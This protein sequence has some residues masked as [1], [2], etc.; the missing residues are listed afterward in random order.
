M[1]ESLT[2]FA[3]L[4]VVILTVALVGPYFVDWTAQRSWIEA[5]LSDATGARVRV[6]GAIDVKLLPTPSLHLEK[7]VLQGPNSNDV[8]FRAADVDLQMAV[9]P[10]LR[11]QVQFIE[12]D[13]EAPEVQVTMAGDG[14]VVLPRVPAKLPAEMQFSAISLRHGRLTIND[15]SHHHIFSVAGLDLDAKAG[16]L[17]GPFE[18][19]G[20]FVPGGGGRVGFHFSTT[21]LHGSHLDLK[22]AIDATANAPAAN[23]D[24]ALEFAS[25]A[26]GSTDV[27]FVG[28]ARFSGRLAL[29]GSAILPWKIRGSLTADARRATFASLRLQLGK[30]GQALIANGSGAIDFSGT[31]RAHAKLR[32][33]QIDIDKLLG[34]KSGDGADLGLFVKA[35]AGALANPKLADRIPIPVDLTFDSPAVM[36]GGG[37]LSDVATVLKLRAGA[38]IGLDFQA[39]GPGRSHLGLSG[40]LDTGVAAAFKGH[41]RVAVGD[42]S[43]LVHWLAPAMPQI[44]DRLRPLPF[45]MIDLTGDME[46]SAAGFVGRNLHIRADRSKLVGTVSFTRAMGRERARVFADLDADALDL[47]A[48]PDLS[49]PAVAAA[50][51][52]LA[53]TLDARAVRVARFGQG[54]IDAGHIHFKLTKEGAK[55]ELKDLSIADL[56]GASV[57]A[58][59]AWT[60]QALRFDAKLDAKRLNDLAALIR[61]VAPGAAANALARRATAL[62]PAHVALTVEGRS[63]NGKLHL[64]GLALR[65]TARGTKI[66]AA[67]R[68]G[69]AESRAVTANLR[70]DATNTPMLLRQIGLE[71]LPLTGFGRAHLG[72]KLS[73]QPSQGFAAEL[74]GML[75]G[76]AV[77]FRGHVG[78][79]PI[80]PRA[81]GSFTVKASNLTPLLEIATVGVP[82]ATT[83]LATKLK[84][85]LTLDRDRLAFTALDG[86]FGESRIKGDL[87]IDLAPVPAKARITGRLAFDR[88]PLAALTT[89]ALGPPQPTKQGALW[90]SGTFVSSLAQ[91][92]TA[93]IAV[94]AAAL[95]LARGAVARQ[96]RLHLALAPSILTLSDV[97]MKIGDGRLAG[98]LTVR[99][100]RSKVLAAGAVDFDGVAFHTRYASGQ[101]SGSL[102]FAATGRSEAALVAS[103]AGSGTVRLSGLTLQ[104][105]DPGALARIVTET[106]RGTV[107]VDAP[108]IRSALKRQLDR[109]ALRVGD[110]T[111]DANMAA[112]VLRLTPKGK[113]AG[114]R[115][116]GASARF[117]AALDLRH[118]RIAARAVLTS[119]SAPRDWKGPPPRAAVVWKGPVGAAKRKLDAGGFFDALASRAL[120]RAAA[121]AEMLEQDIQ[122]R[123]YF[124]RY[125]KGLQFL[126]RREKEI[127][128][129]EAQEARQAEAAQQAAE[130]ARQAR[131]VRA[132]VQQRASAPVVPRLDQNSKSP[133][134]P[135]ALPPPAPP[136]PL[137]L[138]LL[139]DPPASV[140]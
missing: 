31:P 44:S 71:S 14:S 99:R 128:A 27:S 15:P 78:G 120:A 58:T 98:H 125:L 65:G 122:E 36:L 39:D 28:K 66:E 3:G 80:A 4:L 74:H 48:L 109:A 21:V 8:S 81:Q 131:A 138:H 104:K 40:S 115:A 136:R 67:A 57:S 49:G 54:M 96:A 105:S 132:E 140:Q 123:A 121:R 89:L 103:L 26:A 12:A 87:S 137:D 88:L 106:D 11:G 82:D 7:V 107:A 41:V 112:G 62:S 29:I 102:G 33:R 129:Y 93:K 17:V 18:G 30:E 37:T 42:T 34:A 72:L 56:G 55:T 25:G 52:D 53:L 6:A 135:I 127:A 84:G 61:R 19:S 68:P 77:T 2:I 47:D 119:K 64:T 10:L 70:L 63:V 60:P 35:L 69:S 59:G 50:D 20:Q 139:L 86:S 85:R 76:T 124:N 95:D 90:S 38:P 73:G 1:R 117:S 116:A 113:T 9:T 32:S 75:A 92:P 108:E 51:A 24:G 97:A 133:P 83:T 94:S 23:F 79:R 100:D 111:Y 45:Q 5:L 118:A 130:Q 16:S 101:A 126:H 114:S 110:S 91:V 22:A 13:I 43:R 46:V 134:K